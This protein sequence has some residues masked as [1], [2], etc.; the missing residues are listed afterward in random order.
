MKQEVSKAATH[1]LEE[2]II[3]NQRELLIPISASGLVLDLGDG[4][5]SEELIKTVDSF[6]KSAS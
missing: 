3:V 2:T 5:S 1:R 4:H 6:A